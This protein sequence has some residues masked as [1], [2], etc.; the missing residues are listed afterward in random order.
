[1]SG[2]KRYEECVAD[3]LDVFG[4]ERCPSFDERFMSNAIR[5][6]LPKVG[7]QT[8]FFEQWSRWENGYC[9]SFNGKLEMS[10]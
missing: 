10:Y 9:E 5:D 4:P 6:W 2:C 3:Y 8:L 1:M 7:A